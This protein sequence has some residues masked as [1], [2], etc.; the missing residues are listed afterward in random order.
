M[1]K[2]IKIIIFVLLLFFILLGGVFVQGKVVEANSPEQVKYYSVIKLKSGDSLWS[3]AQAHCGDQED[4]RSYIQEIKAI[5]H[6]VN[7]R[8]LKAGSPLTIYYW[9]EAGK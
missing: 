6:I 2:G 5:N 1:R 8:S 9:D 4:I 3:I 7:E